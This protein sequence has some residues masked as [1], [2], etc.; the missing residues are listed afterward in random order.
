MK[1]I[2]TLVFAASLATSAFA[3]EAA[4]FVVDNVEYIVTGEKTV[5]LSGLT[6]EFAAT[7]LTVPSEVV[8][9]GKTYSVTSIEEEAIKWSDL[10][11]LVLPASVTELK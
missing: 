1:K 6:D 4:T 8:N 11:K 9:E 10:T 3:Q 7:E 5:G 2:F